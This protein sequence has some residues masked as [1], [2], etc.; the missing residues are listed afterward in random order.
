MN[1]SVRLSAWETEHTSGN[2]KSER[3]RSNKAE[4]SRTDEAVEG[5]LYIE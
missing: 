5:K 1:G 2:A 4:E 3:T